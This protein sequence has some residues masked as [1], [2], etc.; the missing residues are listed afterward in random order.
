[1]KPFLLFA[2]DFYYPSGGM[3]DLRGA[4]ETLDDAKAAHHGHD[5]AHV[6]EWRDGDD[7]NEAGLWI[8]ATWLS[9]EG[10]WI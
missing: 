5:W 9:A 2:G 1:M 3:D 7:D 6:A 10:E 8:V 4:F